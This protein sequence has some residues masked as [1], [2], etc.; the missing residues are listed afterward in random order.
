[1]SQGQANPNVAITTSNKI[2]SIFPG[3]YAVA[4]E[5]SFYTA[6]LNTTAG[7]AGTAV[8]LTTV[9]LGKTNPNFAIFNSAP[10][11]G[12][13]SY[14]ICLRYVKMTIVATAV[15]GATSCN[16]VGTLDNLVPKLSAVGTAFAT[17]VNTNSASSTLSKAVIY[18]GV[19][20]ASADTSNARNVHA[21][22]VANSIPIALDNWTFTYGDPVTAGSLWAGT[23]ANAKQ[24]LV[25]IPPVI[26]APGWTYTLSFWGASWSA[27]AL[28]LN[29]EVGWIERPTGQ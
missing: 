27:N 2:T 10:V 12:T 5:G 7:T 6:S 9:A 15:T 14:N 19:L 11:G 13:N 21:G 26:I 1:M 8:A 17:P 3:D 18:G 24:I 16:H 29:T 23:A 22:T 25:P 4:D 28:T 20:I